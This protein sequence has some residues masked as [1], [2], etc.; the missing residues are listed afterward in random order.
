MEQS[1][2]STISISFYNDLYLE[3]I[4]NYS[5]GETPF[6]VE[7]IKVLKSIDQNKEIYPIVVS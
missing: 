5:F 6:S 4:L 2:R 7:P 3:Q 1:N